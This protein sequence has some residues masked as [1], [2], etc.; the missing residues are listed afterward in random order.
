MPKKR[1]DELLVERGLVFDLKE[2]RARIL[3]GEIIAGQHRVD[4]AGTLVK[5]DT[6]LRIKTRRKQA[7]VSRGGLKLE[8]AL[9]RTKDAV[10]DAVCLDIGASTGGFTDCLLQHGAQRVYAVDVAYGI[11]DWSLQTHPRV[12]NL[13]RTHAGQLTR[14]QIPESID[15]VVADISFNSL[16]RLLPAAMGFLKDGAFAF[17]LLKP[18][19]EAAAHQVGEGGIMRDA[20]VRNQV[21]SQTK[22]DI[23]ALGFDIRDCFESP[24]R[25]ANGNIEYLII[26]RLLGGQKPLSA[27]VV[28]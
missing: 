12:V 18:Q 25:G 3:A 21:V 10:V 23:E 14:E 6:P 26:A 17:L 15:V 22:E 11:L 20:K 5:S 1:I 19:F 28:E 4:K 8:A 9:A 27:F 7:Y 24:I 2:A 16:G 13:E